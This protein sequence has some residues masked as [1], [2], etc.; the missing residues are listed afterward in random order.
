MLYF[1]HSVF[2]DESDLPADFYRVHDVFMS[3]M[4]Q[5]GRF[6]LLVFYRVAI[7]HFGC[8]GRVYKKPLQN[9]AIECETSVIVVCYHSI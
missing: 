8:P 7:G 4:E 9:S 2:N 1:D 6:A 5:N 3:D